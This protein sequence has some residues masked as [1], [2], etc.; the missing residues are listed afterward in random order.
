MKFG[1]QCLRHCAPFCYHKNMNALWLNR[2]VAY[3]NSPLCIESIR[4]LI[5]LKIE[6]QGNLLQKYKKKSYLSKIES[7]I[8]TQDV[9]IE[10]AR[11]AKYFWRHFRDLVLG[12][13][14]FLSRIPHSKDV[15]NQILDIGYHHITNIVKKILEQHGIPSAIGL[16]HTAREVSSEPLAYDL[17]EIFRADIVDAEALRFLR[18]KKKKF[19]ILEQKDVGHFLH[20]VNERLEQE[21]FLKDFKICHKYRYYME[22]QIL[23]FIKAINHNEVFEP[24]FLPT[25]HED[26]CA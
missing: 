21:F 20:E 8:S 16:L 14:K 22:L 5:G 23:R 26:R 1:A 25:R 2:I 6:R 19:E 11:S 3:K 12:Q 18:L 24:F 4:R 13:T 10:E 17:V 15:L 7:A 9:L